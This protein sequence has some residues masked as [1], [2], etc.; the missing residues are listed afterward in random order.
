MIC[1]TGDIHHMSMH[2][3]GQ[4]YLQNGLTEVIAGLG[5]AKIAQKYDVKVTLFLTGKSIL[6][7]T[8]IVKELSQFENVEIGGH[9]F[10]GNRP[11]WLYA[12]CNKLGMRNGPK[13]YQSWEIKKT[14]RLI[15][16]VT[17]KDCVSWRNH[18][19]REDKNTISLLE[20]VGIKCVSNQVS[21]D[22]LKPRKVGNTSVISVP[23]NVMPDHE[24]IYH[25]ER[26]KELIATIDLSHQP[27]GAT[28]YTVNEWFEV[29]KRQILDIVK[30]DGMATI[31]AHPICMK[32]GD[33]FVT[34]ERLVKFISKYKTILMNE[35]ARIIA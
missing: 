8:K 7:E 1:L 2:T 18:A 34:F 5:Y 14:V 24:H 22:S 28:Q 11:W 13:V 17:G 32:V 25:G 27:F 29:L 15:K 4:K 19:Y 3:S 26:T 16:E 10:S 23:T 35:I 31:L 33:D 9:T 6:E 20:K 30:K 12:I 21:P